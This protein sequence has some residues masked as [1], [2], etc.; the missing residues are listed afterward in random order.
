MSETWYSLPPSPEVSDHEETPAVSEGPAEAPAVILAYAD[1]WLPI[2]ESRSRV[3]GEG[4]EALSDQEAVP[5]PPAD[6]DNE[7]LG[8]GRLFATEELDA[9][10]Q[11]VAEHG[12]TPADQGRILDIRVDDEGTVII[13]AHVEQPLGPEERERHLLRALS[14][15]PRPFED[16]EEDT[17]DDQSES[18]GSDSDAEGVECEET[19]AEEQVSDSIIEVV[20][21]GDNEVMVVAAIELTPAA[22]LARMEQRLYEFLMSLPAWWSTTEKERIARHAFG[23]PPLPLTSDDEETDEE[24]DEESGI[25]SAEEW[26]SSEEEKQEPGNV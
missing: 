10:E 9:T 18:T 2:S 21:D 22:A 11:G 1:D 24:T 19:E 26:A 3:Q 15:T 7:D 13:F 6:P 25:N 20:R 17:Q 5:E 8:L 4:G 16:D 23:Y 14:I 12:Q